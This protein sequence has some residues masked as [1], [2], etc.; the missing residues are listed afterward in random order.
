LRAVLFILM[1]LVFFGCYE[2]TDCLINNTNALKIAFKGKTLGKDTT[3]TFISIRELKT[4]GNLYTN[5]GVSSVSI[6]L[7][8][9]DSTTTVIFYYTE[10]SKPVSDTL[11]VSYLNQ[12][13]VIST[14]CGAYLYQLDVAVL[15]TDFEKVRV[16][17]SVLL[18]TVT[19]N[20]EIFL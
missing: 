17:S 4:P 16:T 15:K 2:Q 8:I 14:D 6:P 20:L 7:Q 12:T 10:K 19:N 13:R 11:T 9:K 18:T 1:V 3:V 5:T